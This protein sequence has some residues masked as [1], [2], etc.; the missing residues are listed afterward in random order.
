MRPT[1]LIG[2]KMTDTEEIREQWAFTPGW[3]IY[4]GPANI[5][6]K[7]LEQFDSMI[8]EVRAKAF[9]DAAFEAARPAGN[10]LM[11]FPERQRIIVNRIRNLF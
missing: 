3:S 4:E 2:E 8:Q 7:R 11:E 9:E 6:Q 10:R 5:R 1:A